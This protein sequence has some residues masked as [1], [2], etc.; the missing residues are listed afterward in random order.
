MNDEPDS[1]IL[2]GGGWTANA[3]FTWLRC[4]RGT[5]TFN[6]K[7]AAVLKL[8]IAVYTADPDVPI[9]ENDIR[10][11]GGFGSSGEWRL[12]WVFNAGKSGRKA[13]PAWLSGM[14]TKV[15]AGLWK[16]NL[17]PVPANG[18]K[19][20]RKRPGQRQSLKVKVVP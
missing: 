7:Q 12:C 20:A 3:S 8:F 10:R 11:A 17:K 5:F 14:F 6:A 9:S 19:M 15:A 18:P 16:L 13:H 1:L 2:R 4:G